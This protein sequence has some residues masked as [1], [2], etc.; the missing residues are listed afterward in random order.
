V[1]HIQF[2]KGWAH[3]WPAWQLDWFKFRLYCH[4]YTHKEIQSNNHRI[5]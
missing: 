5:K 2:W 4:W 3:Q 1:F